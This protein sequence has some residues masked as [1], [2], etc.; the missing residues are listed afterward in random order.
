MNGRVQ[1]FVGICPLDLAWPQRLLFGFCPDLLVDL[2]PQK[3]G[4]YLGK[5]W[6]VHVASEY[7]LVLIHAVDELAFQGLVE[8][9]LEVLERIDHCRLLDMRVRHCFFPDL[10]EEKLIGRLE[11]GSESLI[12]DVDEA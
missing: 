4:D 8:D 7:L 11:L 1:F 10:V 5:G 3:L 12:H 6:I 9:V 2:L